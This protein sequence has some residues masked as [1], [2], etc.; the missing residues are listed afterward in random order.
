[1]K[2]LINGALLLAIV[3]T[4][5]FTSC[6][7]KE[8]YIEPNISETS[9]ELRQEIVS[10][11]PRFYDGGGDNFG[12]IKP[13]GNCLPEVVIDGNKE[14]L[15]HVFTIIENGNNTAISSSFQSNMQLLVEFIDAKTIKE[16]IDNNLE[17][18]HR[19][20]Q[21]HDKHYLLFSKGDEPHSVYPITLK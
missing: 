18:K 12:C 21:T 6:S 1:M 3:G 20:N 8:N 2:Y 10:D 19:Y 13:N 14:P 17:V 15:Q 4:T 11:K 16:V 7:K 9:V 5:L